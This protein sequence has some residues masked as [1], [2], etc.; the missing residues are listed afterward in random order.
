MNNID[1]YDIILELHNTVVS[2]TL[3]IAHLKAD[4]K[5]A[6]TVIKELNTELDNELQR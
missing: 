6:G 3:E 2:Q 1:P 5:A 4:L